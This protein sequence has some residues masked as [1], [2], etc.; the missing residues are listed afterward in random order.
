[1]NGMA[2]VALRSCWRCGRAWIRTGRNADRPSRWKP[3][4]ALAHRSAVPRFHRVTP[5]LTCC[6]N[7][8]EPPHDS[9]RQRNEADE[10]RAA[11]LVKEWML[12]IDWIEADLEA[13]L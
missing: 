13:I 3:C 4:S 1:M 2:P 8:T 5:R 9:P 10:R 12:N 7:H 6:S 11:Q